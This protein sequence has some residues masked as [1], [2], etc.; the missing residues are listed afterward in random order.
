[1]KWMPL[2]GVC[3]AT[4]PGTERQATSDVIW[5]DIWGGSV[6]VLQTSKIVILLTL[7]SITSYL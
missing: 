7:L 5:P 3:A 4:L 2:P 1:M 6:P